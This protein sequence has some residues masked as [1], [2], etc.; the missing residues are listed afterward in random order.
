MRFNAVDPAAEKTVLHYASYVDFGRYPQNGKFE[1]AVGTVAAEKL[2]VGI[3]T[4]P[5]R[6]ELEELVQQTAQSESDKEFI[7]SLY[8]TAKAP[9]GLFSVALEANIAGNER[10]A[11]KRS[12]SRDDL[13]RLWALIAE[14]DRN[15]VR[16]NAVIDIKAVPETIRPAQ[17]EGELM[18]S[19]REEDKELVKAAYTYEEFI[20]V[21][22]LTEENET[23]KDQVLSAM[24]RAGFRGAVRHV[25]QL[26][27]AVVVGIINSPDPAPNG[28]VGYIPLDALQDE[29]GMM[30]EGAVTELLI[31]RKDAPYSELPDASESAKAITAA[32]ERGLLGEPLPDHLAVFFWMDYMKDY[33][34]FE[35]LQTTAPQI[36]AFLLLFISF[37]GISNTILLF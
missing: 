19:L 9:G 10:M 5:R 31:R 25:N 21:Y 2:R 14:T 7:R 36:L 15:N 4:R 8:E 1:L 16:I 18:T 24:I 23:R 33:L 37:L 17:W 32:L 35:A 12:A 3:P 27:D 28:N 29:S 13:D 20:G 11:L 6:L 34:G 26:V 30:L 22:L